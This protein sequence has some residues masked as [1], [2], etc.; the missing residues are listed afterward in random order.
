M[1]VFLMQQGF[2]LTII[3]NNDRKKYYRVLAQAD[4]KNFKPLTLFIAQAVER[5]LDLFLKTLTPVT[6]NREEYLPLSDLAEHTPYSAKYLNLLI[7]KGKLAGHKEG[8]IWLSTREAVAG[9]I[10]NRKRQVL[11]K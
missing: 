11:N 5:T 8:R 1:N 2:P 4:L 3:L 9:Y 10:K 7:R 6:E